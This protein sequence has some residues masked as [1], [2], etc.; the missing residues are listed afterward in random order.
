MNINITDKEF[1]YAGEIAHYAALLL[2]VVLTSVAMLGLPNRSAYDSWWTSNGFCVVEG[3][4]VPT[5]VLCFLSL[6]A[7]AVSM[8]FFSGHHATYLKESSP[9]LLQRMRA[10]IFG[11]FAHGFGH[12][13]LW[14]MGA[15]PRLELSLEPAA[16]ANILMLMMFWVGT[17][18]ALVDLP[19]NNAAAAAVA[20]LGIQ[21][22]LGVPPEL[23]FTYSQSIILL[24]T[25]LNQLRK[26]NEYLSGDDS[27]L[28]FVFALYQLPLF[29][30]YYL[31]MFSCSDS[32]L[33]KL[34]GHTVYDAYL[35]IAPF[36]IYYAVNAMK[37]DSMME[38]KKGH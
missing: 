8:Y 31:E 7:S 11:N 15:S 27:F 17:L 26:K 9:L 20:V 19:T 22:M 4:E 21:W 24:A 18:R 37:N 35:A 25:S 38:K 2:N 13:F 23:A 5:E 16:L 33:S 3:N 32:V 1:I 30:L 14:F 6:A 28:Y 10:S 29:S 12:V 36:G 34:G